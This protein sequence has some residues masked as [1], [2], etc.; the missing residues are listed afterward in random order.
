MTTN[1]WV[2]SGTIHEA[3]GS[4]RVS[5][6]TMIA[7]NLRTGETLSFTTDANGEYVFDCGNFT[8]GY[9]NVDRIRIYAGKEVLEGAQAVKRLSRILIKNLKDYWRSDFK[10]E[11][12]NVEIVTNHPLPIEEKYEI[13]RHHIEIRL[14]DINV[15]E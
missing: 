12:A 5:G 2:V 8:S 1:P 13:F 6:V 4:T 15:G 10:T 7:I 3:D 14:N 11:M 9:N